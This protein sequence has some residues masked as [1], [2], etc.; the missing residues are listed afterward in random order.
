M[1]RTLLAA[2]SRNR[3]PPRAY[4]ATDTLFGNDTVN[5]Q[6]FAFVSRTSLV[7]NMG[8]VLVFEVFKGRDDRIRGRLPQAAQRGFLHGKRNVP[9]MIDIID[10]C[11][12]RGYLVHEIEELTAS[13]AA[14]RAFAA[15]FI[16]RKLKVEFGDVTMQ[17]SSSMTIMPPEPIMEPS[18]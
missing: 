10:G 18:R 1:R 11:L 12:S 13:Y 9:D 7:R 6:R 14:R 5:N 8:H 2:D 4:T 17:S 15:G 3:A 16:D